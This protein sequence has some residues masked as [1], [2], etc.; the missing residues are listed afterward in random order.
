MT[1]YYD[2]PQIIYKC[3]GNF[4]DPFDDWKFIV[5]LELIVSMT[6][7]NVLI[8]IFLSLVLK[9]KIIFGAYIISGCVSGSVV[10]LQ[11]ECGMCYRVFNL[12]LW[13]WFSQKIECVRWSTERFHPV[14]SMSCYNE[15]L[16]PSCTYC[17]KRF[18]NIKII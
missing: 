17:W 16:G 15:L 4:R 14:F 7:K 1:G 10:L 2:M 8:I 12:W 6:I 3:R 9:K 13:L 11:W 18:V 5:S